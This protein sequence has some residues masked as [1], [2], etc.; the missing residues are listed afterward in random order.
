MDHALVMRGSTLAPAL[1]WSLLILC[2]APV[3]AQ[4]TVEV[5]EPV[6]AVAAHVV[7]S[8]EQ[9]SIFVQTREG[10]YLVLDHRAHTVHRLAAGATVARPMLG[11]G[12]EPGRV[13]RP[14]TMALGDN[15][16]LA[17]LDGP[18][19]YQRV[20]FFTTDGRLIGGYFLPDSAPAGLVAAGQTIGSTGMLALDGSSVWINVPAWGAL[21]SALDISGSAVR[22]VGQLRPTGFESNRALHEALN[23]GIPVVDPQGGLYFVFQAGV[24]VLRRYDAKGTLVFERHIEGVEVDPI[25]QRLPNTWL[26]REDGSRPLPAP[27]VRT[28]ALDRRG[29]LWVLLQTGHVYVYDR[30]GEKRRVLAF[31]VPGGT[32]PVSLSFTSNGR[33]LV[34]PGGYEFVVPPA[35]GHN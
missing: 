9:P 32:I 14:T 7:H 15:D 1:L 30:S 26:A 10:H 5:F 22:H 4:R 2:P 25:I 31:A 33:V 8:F 21:M 24:P 27:V 18:G 16:V 19:R 28:A 35:A 12:P 20:Q 29:D 23:A 34:G 11:I 6:H 13:L 3:W 17:V